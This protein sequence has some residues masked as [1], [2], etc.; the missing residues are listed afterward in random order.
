MLATKLRA[1]YQRK[2]GRDLFDLWFALENFH[3]VDSNAV[4]AMFQ[5]YLFR[6]GEQIARTMFEQNVLA[7]SKQESF[8]NDIVPLI[9]TGVD[10]DFDVALAV[11]MESF[12]SLLE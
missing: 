3:D 10:W 1:L 6:G 4:V 7:K 5:T 8:R 2:K 11:V 9:R 12:V